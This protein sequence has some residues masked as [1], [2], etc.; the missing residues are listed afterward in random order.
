MTEEWPVFLL[1]GL[2]NG[3]ATGARLG[4]ARSTAHQLGAATAA[5]GAGFI[6]TQTGEYTAAFLAGR[7]ARAGR[8]SRGAADPA[9]AGRGAEAPLP[10][11]MS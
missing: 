4:P 9:G 8:R 6:R 11:P 7:R 10:A 5:W 1:W 3:S 2:V